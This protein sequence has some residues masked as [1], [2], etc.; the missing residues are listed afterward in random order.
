MGMLTKAHTTHE[1]KLKWQHQEAVES[2]RDT[3]RGQED[4]QGSEATGLALLPEVTQK[5]ALEDKRETLVD[6]VTLT[7]HSTPPL[8]MYHGCSG[9]C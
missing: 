2:G 3:S 4:L 7:N 5:V 8:G 6:S 1:A 9:W